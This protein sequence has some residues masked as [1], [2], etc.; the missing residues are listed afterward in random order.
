M[1]VIE[2]M[3]SLYAKILRVGD[4]AQQDEK[5]LENVL[6]YFANGSDLSEKK[7]RTY[8]KEFNGGCMRGKLRS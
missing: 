5:V 8:I 4:V 1:T 6:L 2:R 7:R 3:S